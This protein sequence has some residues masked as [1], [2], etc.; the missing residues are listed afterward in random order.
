MKNLPSGGFGARGNPHRASAP[1]VGVNTNDIWSAYK[2]SATLKFSAECPGELEAKLE[3]IDITD[4]AEIMV[5]A[6]SASRQWTAVLSPPSP[7]GR[8]QTQQQTRR[9]QPQLA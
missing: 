1:R 6:R 8:R 4:V 5:S 9:L 7:L 3:R 2:I